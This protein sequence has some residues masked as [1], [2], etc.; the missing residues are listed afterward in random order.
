M[1]ARNT[2]FLG[3]IDRA[4]A[5]AGA[6]ASQGPKLLAALQ[7]LRGQI[8]S[9]S[10][11][12]SDW[13]G[14]W[15]TRPDRWTRRCFRRWGIWSVFTKSA[16]RSRR[17][18]VHPVLGCR[19]SITAE[20]PLASETAKGTIWMGPPDCDHPDCGQKNDFWPSLTASG[21]QRERTGL[22]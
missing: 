7:S 18:V 9:G 19:S 3:L 4:V 22:A 1:D 20:S 12:P 16:T 10:L 15:P 17:E 2:E 8:E 11:A 21:W 5:A 6:D 13:P 14:T